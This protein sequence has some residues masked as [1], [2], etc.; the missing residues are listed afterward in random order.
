MTWFALHFSNLYP[1]KCLQVI[2][3]DGTAINPKAALGYKEKSE[4]TDISEITNENLKSLYDNMLE[5][6]IEDKKS[7]FNPTLNKYSDK[8]LEIAFSYYF[9]V[10]EKRIEWYCKSSCLIF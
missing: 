4:K 10:I 8:I 6:V 5:N 9:R 3:L 1:D 7:S 2:F